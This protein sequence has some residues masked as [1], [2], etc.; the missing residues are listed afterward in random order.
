MLAKVTHYD[1]DNKPEIRFVVMS[2]VQVPKQ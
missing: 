2:L 1:H